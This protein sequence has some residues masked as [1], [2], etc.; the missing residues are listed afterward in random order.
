MLNMMRLSPEQVVA[1]FDVALEGG[2]DTTS[3]TL[4]YCTVIAAKYTNIQDEVFKELDEICDL[5]SKKIE[6]IDV[7]DKI[8]SLHKLRAFIFEA[9]RLNPVVPGGGFRQLRKENGLKI[10][11]DGIKYILPDKAII[12][13]NILGMQ[14]NPKLWRNPDKFDINR[15]LDKDGKFNRKLNPTI[16]NFSFGI[17]DCPGRPLALKTLY[18][19][20]A[21]LFSRYRF[22]FD[23]P[24]K[25]K[26]NKKLEFVLHVHP[27]IPCKVVGR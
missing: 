18:L 4:E 14:M 3:G 16:M 15:W 2:A 24:E 7:L 10:N 21:I 17:R 26:I 13:P 8:S 1:D 12:M 25:V 5:S 23:E 27:E 20:M 6:D 19:V 11:V 22:Y 9:M